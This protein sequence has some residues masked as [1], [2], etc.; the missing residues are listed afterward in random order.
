MELF[1]SFKKSTCMIH[2]WSLA[3]ALLEGGGQMRAEVGVNKGKKT[4]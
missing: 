3:C 1:E 2:C 4:A